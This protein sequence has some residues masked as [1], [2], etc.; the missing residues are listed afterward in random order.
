M[1]NGTCQCLPFY[2][3]DRCQTFK[4]CDQI[5]PL[6]C[7]Q[8]KTANEVEE[9]DLPTQIIVNTT[10]TP[11]ETTNQDN[12]QTDTNTTSQDPSTTP[13]DQNTEV[14]P[15]S[16]NTNTS[17]DTSTT[18]SE[19][20]TT[21]ADSGNINVNQDDTLAFQDILTGNQSQNEDTDSSNTNNNSN[22]GTQDSG[23]NTTRPSDS[24]SVSLLF[25][26][27]SF[28]LTALYLV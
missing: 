3:G 5:L 9:F 28:A 22:V 12:T 27:F 14:T 17:S 4:D 19:N 13:S 1:E 2:E 20:N 10:P 18:N 25:S 26:F 7:S 6:S 15:T 24:G 8:I 21:S 11:S 16:T 23:V